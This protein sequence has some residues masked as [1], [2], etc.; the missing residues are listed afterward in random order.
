MKIR[1]QT[2]LS[3]LSVIVPVLTMLRPTP[4]VA[5]AAPDLAWKCW[6]GRTWP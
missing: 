5:D 4:G 2:L 3:L 6:L 1:I